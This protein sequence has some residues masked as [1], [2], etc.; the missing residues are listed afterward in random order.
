MD[1]IEMSNLFDVLFNNITSNQSPGLDEY[2]KSVFL[3]KAQNQLVTEYFNRRV[4][5][6]GGG[7]DGSQ[8]R[9]YD[10]SSLIKIEVV[11]QITGD[12]LL[13]FTQLDKRS[14]CYAFPADYFLAVN[15]ALEDSRYQYTVMPISYDEYMRLMQKPY[16]YPIKKGAWRMITGRHAS[17]GATADGGLKVTS[18]IDKEFSLG[19]GTCWFTSGAS[20]S[21]WYGQSPVT[22][23]L[24]KDPAEVH[25]LIAESPLDVTTSGI[26]FKPTIDANYY[27]LLQVYEST[28][29]SQIRLFQIGG[30]RDILT[31]LAALTFARAALLKYKRANPN[32]D[33]KYT[34]MYPVIDSLRFEGGSQVLSTTSFALDKTAID[35]YQSSYS[36]DFAAKKFT[37]AYSTSVP[38]VE[39]IGRFV[40]D[41][42]YTLRYVKRP[43]P[44]ILVDLGVDYG[45]GLNIDGVTTVSQCELP[46]ET[47]QE[48]VER[49]VTLAKIAWAGGTATQAAAQQNRES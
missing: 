24:A 11:P 32:T 39:I 43:A 18:T 30:T 28:N 22:T 33:D 35:S 7:F 47:H 38:V 27:F 41:L 45:N 17:Y 14:L 16:A 34:R 5:Q 20:S 40:G 42:T 3:T 19:I 44:I 21:V 36:E 9:Q 23:W 31:G 29:S 6:I 4:D 8:K 46:E 26:E 2:E 49:A 1:R 37:F 48:I 10:F 15:E 13:T 12:S 25:S